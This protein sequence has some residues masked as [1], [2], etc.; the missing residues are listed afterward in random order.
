MS[1]QRGF[2]RAYSRDMHGELDL[3]LVPESISLWYEASMRE[4]KNLEDD[5]NIDSDDYSEEE[6]SW[7]FNF[8]F[9]LPIRIIH[10]AQ[11]FSG[12]GNQLGLNA[13][14]LQFLLDELFFISDL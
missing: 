5:L 8:H 11:S 2:V 1:I 4:D 14:Y 9:K 6:S 3:E 13:V 12:T 10:F 7:N